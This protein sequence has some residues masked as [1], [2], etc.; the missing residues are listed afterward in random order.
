M[1]ISE[2]TSRFALTL[3]TQLLNRMKKSV[4]LSLFMLFTAIAFGQNKMDSW[5]ELKDFHAIMSQTFHPSEDGN[6]QPIKQRADEL[7]QKAMALYDSK[8]P[9]EFDTPKMKDATFRLATECKLIVGMIADKKSDEEITKKLAA[10]HDVFHEIVG[11][12]NDGGAEKGGHDHSDPN[13]KH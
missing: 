4:V 8:R 6:L 3:I 9:A 12:C 5:A 10:A 7:L 13:H 1:H 11:L 2:K